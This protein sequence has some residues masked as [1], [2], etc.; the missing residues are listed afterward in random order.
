MLR[1]AL[2]GVGLCAGFA[3]APACAFD[4]S[5]SGSAT[6][7]TPVEAFRSGTEALRTG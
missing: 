2:L 5:K 1:V 6:P 7:L 3:V 4:G